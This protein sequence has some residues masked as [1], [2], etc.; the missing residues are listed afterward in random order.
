M[1]RLPV[2]LHPAANDAAQHPHLHCTDLNVVQLRCQGV[3]SRVALC[4]SGQ[5]RL[6]VAP[7]LPIDDCSY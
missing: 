1:R 2:C 5:H 7:D 4:A 6:E 3:G